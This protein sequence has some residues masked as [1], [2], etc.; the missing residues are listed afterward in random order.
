M[1]SPYCTVYHKK[2]GEAYFTYASTVKEWLETGDYTTEK[3]ANA[4]PSPEASRAK[5]PTAGREANR[6]APIVSGNSLDLEGNM[7]DGLKVEEPAEPVMEKPAK[8]APR[9]RAASQD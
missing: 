2:T 5:L 6:E 7:S 1:A 4:K 9:R 3:P 8:P